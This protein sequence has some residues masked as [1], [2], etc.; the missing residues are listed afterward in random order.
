MPPSE[1]RIA[2]YQPDIP[3][4]AGTILRLAA[5]LGLVVDIVGQA[6]FDLADR[7]LRRAG[8]D[9]LEMAA[10][11]RHVDFAAFEAAVLPG[12][13]LV[14][15]TTRA[16]LPYT[17]FAFA[18]TDVLLFGRELAGVPERPRT[19]RGAAAD[20]HAGRRPQPERGARRG[21]GRRRGA[22]PMRAPGV[23]QTL[24][25][26]KLRSAKPATG[27]EVQVNLKSRPLACLAGPFGGRRLRQQPP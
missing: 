4:N 26:S 15:L 7:A 20:P 1:L 17:D 10:L 12:R 19:R 8:M 27:L 13:R 14:L 9:Y 3:G 23:G 24:A 25:W 16:D 18:P 21:D 11:A 2:L 5:C 6:G 22:A